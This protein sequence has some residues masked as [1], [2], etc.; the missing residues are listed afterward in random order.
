MAQSGADRLKDLAKSANIPRDLIRTI[1]KD[2]TAKQERKVVQKINNSSYAA[3]NSIKV[4]TGNTKNGVKTQVGSGQRVATGGMGGRGA[5]NARINEPPKATNKNS[6]G[7]GGGGGGS[8]GGG[9]GGGGGGSMSGPAPS[10]MSSPSGGMS[11]GSGGS[12][13]GGGMGGGG[14]GGGMGMGMSDINLKTNI[15][16]VNNALNRLINLNLK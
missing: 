6:G 10:P 13:G 1:D 15:I 7:G 8:M 14:M 11:G 3:V 2:M 9:G 4:S 12:M 5:T 16:K